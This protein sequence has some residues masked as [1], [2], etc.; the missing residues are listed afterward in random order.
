MAE[1]SYQEL[2]TLA[3]DFT[4]LLHSAEESGSPDAESKTTTT[5]DGLANRSV[6]S[7]ARQLSNMSF[8]SSTGTNNENKITPEPVEAEEETRSTGKIS[9]EVYSSYFFS[10][11]RMRMLLGL[12]F[13]CIATQVLTSGGDYW[14]AAW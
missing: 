10:C 14:M 1:G 11:E 5:T 6:S 12:F 3:L 13:A 7:I 8:A 2:Q 4:K 9:S